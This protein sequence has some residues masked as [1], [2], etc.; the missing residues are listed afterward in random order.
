MSKEFCPVNSYDQTCMGDT[1]AWWVE[2]GQA[3]SLEVIA[4]ALINYT[5]IKLTEEED[6]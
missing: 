2:D 4:K 5:T 3:C 1:C 6:A